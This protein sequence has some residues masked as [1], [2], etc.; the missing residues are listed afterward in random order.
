MAGR[1]R[2]A[3][4]PQVDR[5]KK[6]EDWSTFDEAAALL[7]VSAVQV[8]NLVFRAAFRPFDA[9]EIRAVGGRP[10][11]LIKTSA[12]LRVKGARAAVAKVKATG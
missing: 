11:Y 8:F 6:L 1:R 4:P 9:S 5:V 10:L 7:D 3:D 2:L 12:V